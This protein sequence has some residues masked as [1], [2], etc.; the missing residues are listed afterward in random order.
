MGDKARDY[1]PSTIKRLFALSNNQCYEPSCT[2]KLISK[3]DDKIIL[4]KISHIE[5]AGENG[6]RC[7]DNITDDERR[8]FNNLILLCDEHHLT[9]DNKENESIYPVELLQQWKYN[10]ENK[11]LSASKIKLTKLPSNDLFIGRE[12]ELKKIHN[13]LIK[14]KQLL[15][16]NG[17]GG[18]GKTTLAIEYLNKYIG[19]YDHISFVEFNNNIKDSFLTAFKNQFDLKSKTSDERFDEL[20]IELENIKGKNLLVI[21]DIKIEDEFNLIK[22]LKSN[23]ELLIT[24]RRQFDTI[25]HQPVIQLPKEKAEELFLRHFKTDENID[26]ILEYLD[27]HTLFIELTA[28][29]LSKSNILTINKLEEK[30]QN[31]QFDT[32]KDATKKKDFNQYLNEL[33]QIDTLNESEVLLLKKLSLFPSVEI[34]FEKLKD[35][36]CIDEEN[37]EEF[38]ENLISLTNS[39]WLIKNNSSFKLHQIIKEFLLKNHKITYKKAEDIIQNFI[40]KIYPLPTDN[41]IEKFEYLSFGVSI[42]NNINKNNTK[43]LI[44]LTCIGIIYKNMGELNKA[45]KYYLKVLQ[46]AE[47]IL[48]K[49]DSDFAASYNN[50]SSIYQAMGELPKALEYQKKSLI[51]TEVLGD[52]HSNSA[53]IFNNISSIYQDMGEVSKA[54]EYQN[55]ALEIRKEILGD[56]HPDLA[57]SYNNIS[58]IYHNMGELPKAVEYQNKGLKIREDILE[59]KHPSLAISYS[60]IS[61]LYNDLK[62]YKKAKE[63][64]EKAINIWEQYDYYKKDLFNASVY[65]KKLNLT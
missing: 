12:D 50:I 53:L 61:I 14:E 7:N 63:F 15:L 59:D 10:H 9:I 4:A 48:E 20:I 25:H 26:K 51:L 32:I 41:P 13:N 38:D 18:I 39:G 65:I 33:F 3:N 37:I 21:D 58:T 30:F 22:D 60:N 57:Q 5:S 36:L 6:P 34:E 11:T 43:L 62:E 40:E 47:I 64:M 1:K 46:I 29:V 55:K 8:D 16:L 28:K 17:I 52:K 31:K 19:Y 27:Y 35:F 42:S 56:N 54:L 24:S 44:L 49:N 23:F 45:L 2:K